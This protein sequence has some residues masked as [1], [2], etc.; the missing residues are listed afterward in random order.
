MK[1]THVE[2]RTVRN[3]V[4]TTNSIVI[5]LDGIA[6]RELRRGV[7]AFLGH[8]S[9]QRWLRDQAPAIKKHLGGVIQ[10][11]GTT[12]LGNPRMEAL[13]SDVFAFTSAENEPFMYVNEMLW[14][15]ACKLAE[16]LKVPH[17]TYGAKTG[18]SRE[19]FTGLECVDESDA[20]A[21]FNS[22]ADRFEDENTGSP[23]DDFNAAAR[24][25]KLRE[26]DAR[27]GRSN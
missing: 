3:E 17:D 21:V 2:S 8:E 27:R 9:A 4:A 23:L 1:I 14:A 18:L 6:D 15:T 12:K 26:A 10:L 16:R 11:H 7:E 25:K 5:D 20:L 13:G 19:L 24:N 22:G